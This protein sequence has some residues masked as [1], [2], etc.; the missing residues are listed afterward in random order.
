[1]IRIKTSDSTK[2]YL[3]ELNI[4]KHKVLYDFE[5]SIK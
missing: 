5:E 2:K 1:M 4:N 3:N